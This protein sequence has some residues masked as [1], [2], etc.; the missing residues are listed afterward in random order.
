VVALVVIQD[1][2]SRLAELAT[3]SH[4]WLANTPA[5]WAAAQRVWRESDGKHALDRGVT[6]FDADTAASPSL[7]V[8]GQLGT[9]DEHHPRCSRLEVFG[10][11]LTPELVAHLL[12][13]GFTEVAPNAEGFTARRS[14]EAQ[15]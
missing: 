11:R 9:I 6:V 7:L 12:Q 4:V 2:G 1:F 10:A 15:A 13:L 8:G 5:N 3:R 14:L